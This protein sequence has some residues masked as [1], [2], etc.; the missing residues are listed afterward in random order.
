MKQRIILDRGHRDFQFVPKEVWHYRTASASLRVQM[1]NIRDRH[2][3]LKIE[4]VHPFQVSIKNGRPESTRLNSF[5]VLIDAL[6]SSKK[7]LARLEEVPVMI[8]V[9]NVDFK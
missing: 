2:V 5:S 3:I 7:L 6:R 4:G 8:E 9:V 1:R